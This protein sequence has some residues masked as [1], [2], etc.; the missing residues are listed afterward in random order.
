M[1][2]L[3]SDDGNVNGIGGY[4]STD[5]LYHLAPESMSY[6]DIL[7]ASSQPSPL[8]NN[9]PLHSAATS[10]APP[11]SFPPSTAPAPSTPVNQPQRL[12]SQSAYQQS[13]YQQSAYQ[14]SAYQPYA[15]AGWNNAPVAYVSDPRSSPSVS[16]LDQLWEK[17]RAILKLC[18]LALV[19]MLAISSHATVWHYL[20]EFVN[21]N[22]L[23]EQKELALRIAYPV[24]VLFVLWHIKAFFVGTD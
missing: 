4:D 24:I 2:L 3:G 16:Y 22:D 1:M 20:T 19:V 13:A 14:Q 7:A 15:A 9:S 11:S 23:S 17:R 5:G 8:S 6:Q 12:P 21:S 10:P 18:V